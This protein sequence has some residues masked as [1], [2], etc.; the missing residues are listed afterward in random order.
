MKHRNILFTL[1]ALGL[2]AALVAALVWYCD[3]YVNWQPKVYP[4][5]VCAAIFGAAA[6]SL[7]TL[8]V[9]GEKGKALGMKTLLSTAIFAGVLIGV[10]AII[11]NGIYGGGKPG[12]SIAASI[13]LPLASAQV[14]VLLTLVLHALRRKLLGFGFVVILLLAVFVYFGGPQTVER[15]RTPPPAVNLAEGQKPYML[16]YNAPA[17]N[18]YMA[19]ESR[20]EG[21]WAW[22]ND[23]DWEQWSLPL[24]CGHF[25]ANVFGR[26]D[27]ERIQ[28]TEASLANPY[29]NGMNN[30][31]EVLIDFHHPER[32]V[33]RYTR[34]LV[35]NDATA[36]VSYQ[37][38][39]VTYER[40]YLTSYPDAV[41]AVRLTASQAGSVSFTLR[42]GIPYLRPFGK[43]GSL[44]KSGTVTAEGDTIT[45]SGEMEHY[46][47]LYE[48][49]IRVLHEGG[50]LQAGDGKINLEGADSAVILMAL[51]TNYVLDESVFLEPDHEKKLEGSPHPHQ[52]VTDTLD[53]AAKLGYDEI[54]RRHVE[55]YQEYFSRVNL[56]LGG[57][58]PEIPTD[59]LLRNYQKGKTNPYLEELYFQYGRYLLIASSRKGTLPG[60]LQGLWNQ[61]EKSPWSAGYW[62]N[63]NIQM[64]YWPAFTTNLA[65]LFEPYADL[66]RAFRRQAQGFADSYLLQIREENPDKEYAV[67]MAEPGTGQNGW[68]VGTGVWPYSAS[69]PAPNSHSG[70]GTG[71]LTAK[72][73]WDWYDYTRDGE[74][75]RDTVY[76]ALSG[77]ADFLSRTVIEQDG[78]LLAYPSASPEQLV[79]GEYYQTTGCAFDQQMIYENHRD[80]I[81]AAEILG[82]D[83]ETVHIA[84]AQLGRLDPVLIG[85]SG[86]VKEYR[87]E[88]R[89]GEIV[90]EY[91]HRHI[92]QLMGLVPGQTINSDTP[93]WL[94]AARVTLT[95]RG[96]RSTGWAMALRLCAWARARDGGHAYL[97]YQNLLKAGTLPNLWDTHPPFQ[98]DGNFG[99]TAG[100]AEMLLQSN[101]NLIEPLPALPDA[102][103]SG[104]FEGL[105]AR[106][107]FV[108]GCAWEAGRL[109]EMTVES[110]SGGELRVRYP[111]IAG[112]SDE[113]TID[114]AVGEVYTITM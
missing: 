67:P 108:V 62:H 83:D 41:L 24:G 80:T 114:T 105:V 61:Y 112:D 8:A 42:P 18:R 66:N 104:S 12:P 76:P 69:G 91:T 98:I 65:E 35:L 54:R 9:R 51:G 99:G 74:R 14:L 10:S 64:N 53:N 4:L 38:K 72:L 17:P 100:V 46:G 59:R 26:T 77:M 79:D 82:I 45:L 33:R 84:K 2:G 31:A 50:T 97:L 47:I 93:E 5:A 3:V 71:G 48:G 29:P 103:A 11:N 109:T 106:G 56:D 52:R 85:D 92:S 13:A 27:T 102:W 87:E 7:L 19:E 89:Y 95:E 73:F 75:L 58:L 43:E 63:I 88:G 49:Q 30:F 111:G 1:L 96:D 107:N 94:Q 25:G 21:A 36:H 39:G 6:L 15:M 110:R 78:L 70:P 113:L 34:D 23:P 55:D 68:A 90:D 20:P 16:W 37:Y 60:N 22:P 40:E 32:R 86:Q 101:G 44:G 57:A 28:V 81:N